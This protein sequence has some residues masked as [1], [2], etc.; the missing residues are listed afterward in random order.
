MEWLADTYTI[1][2]GDA[3]AGWCGRAWNWDKNK[4][5]TLVASHMTRSRQTKYRLR[6]FQVYLYSSTGNPRTGIIPRLFI[7]ADPV[8]TGFCIPL[9]AGLQGT[10]EICH[11]E[12]DEPFLAGCLWRLM[13]GS[14]TAGDIVESTVAYEGLRG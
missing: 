12:G 8:Y 9:E 4:W 2:A 14:S 7:V 13:L 5:E 11:W 10:T 1:Q 3:V 6:S